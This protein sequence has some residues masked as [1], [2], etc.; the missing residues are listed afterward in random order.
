MR[1]TSKTLWKLWVSSVTA[2]KSLS[3][4]DVRLSRVKSIRRGCIRAN[5]GRPAKSGRTFSSFSFHISID[6]Y[7]QLGFSLLYQ[8][9]NMLGFLVQAVFVLLFVHISSAVPAYFSRV[10][11]LTSATLYCDG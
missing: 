7:S 10:P 11:Q 6:L 1:R 5:L 4:P 3:F 2:T 8:I 9:E